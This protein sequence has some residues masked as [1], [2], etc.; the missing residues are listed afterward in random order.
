VVKIKDTMLR[1]TTL[2]FQRFYKITD[3]DVAVS[4]AEV[5]SESNALKQND[6]AENRI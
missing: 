4:V 1:Q 3:V 5:Y 6:A 2:P